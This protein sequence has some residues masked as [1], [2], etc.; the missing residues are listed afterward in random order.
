MLENKRKMRTPS[1]IARKA[2]KPRV[3]ESPWCGH[4]LTQKLHRILDVEAPRRDVEGPTDITAVLGCPLSREQVQR[5]L[6]KF[7]RVLAGWAALGS[8]I[9]IARAL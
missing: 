7:A 1:K 4:H 5:C 8:S 2:V 9:C 3:A 6:I